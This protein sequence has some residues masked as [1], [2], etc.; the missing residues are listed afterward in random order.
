MPS[1]RLRVVVAG[2]GVAGLETLMALRALAGDRLELTLIAPQD[3][4]VYRPLAVA[5]PFAV[6]RARRI[7]LQVAAR[8]ADAT[9]VA[10]TV[11]AVDADEKVVSPSDGDPLQYDALVLAV[12]AH[13]QPVVGHAMTWDDRADSEMLGGLLQDVEQS[14]TRRLAVVIPPGPAWPLRGYELAVFIARHAKGMS[15]EL[16]TTI[17]TPEPSPLAALGSRALEQLSNELALAGVDVVSTARFE[18]EPGR[19]DAVWK[20]IASSRS[21]GCAGARSPAYPR[22]PKASSRSTSTAACAGS[23]ACGLSAMAR[24]SP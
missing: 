11:E 9:Y 8:D 14:Y 16:D 18:V 17:V 12:G 7:T 23:T 15:A 10:G 1:A 4:F 20:S 21:L 24:T 13:A 3:E 19:R 2:A 6:G 22:T 5:E